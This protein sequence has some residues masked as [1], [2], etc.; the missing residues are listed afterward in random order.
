MHWICE[1]PNDI[2]RERLEWFVINITR[3]PDPVDAL[4][5]IIAAETIYV[6]FVN[7]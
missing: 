7:K 6:V 3:R 4:V 2:R 5:G 1:I